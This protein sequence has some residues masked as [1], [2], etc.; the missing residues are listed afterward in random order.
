MRELNLLTVFAGKVAI[1]QEDCGP[2][3]VTLRHVVIDEAM[4]D[5][6][7]GEI[8]SDE[9]QRWLTSEKSGV[10]DLLLPCGH[11]KACEGL[12]GESGDKPGCGWCADLQDLS[13]LAGHLSTVYDHF[14]EGRITK[15]NTLPEEVIRLAGDLETDRAEKEVGEAMGSLW[16]EVYALGGTAAEGD[17]KGQGYCE[18]VAAALKLI[19]AVGGKDWAPAEQAWRYLL[20]NGGIVEVREKVRILRELAAQDAVLSA[21]LTA[22]AACLER[23]LEAAEVR[24]APAAQGGLF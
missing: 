9:V 13:M 18:G 5:D 24:Q 8:G 20:M 17:L 3:E 12:A 19:E 22:S 1:S 2:V 15:P 6:V 21:D 14:S 11:P 7:L 23:C 4:I 10:A 16:A